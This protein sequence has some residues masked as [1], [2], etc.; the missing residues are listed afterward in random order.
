MSG[1]GEESP[2][3]RFLSPELP[4]LESIDRYFE[5]ARSAGWYSNEGPCYRLFVSRAQA[6]LGDDLFVV[7][8]A[9]CTLGL[10]L[11]LRALAG[12]PE[13]VKREVVVPSFT[14][15]ATAAAIEWAG[16][17]PVFADVDPVSWH[18]DPAALE[19]ALRER[20]QRVAGVLACSTFGV[21]PDPQ[22]T[23]AWERLTAAAGVPL[24][25]DSAAGFGATRRNGQRL[26]RQGD[27][28]AFSFHATKPFAVGEG[29]AV[30]TR[31]ESLADRIRVLTNFGFGPDRVIQGEAGL[32]AKLDEW[33]AAACLAALDTI[34]EVIAARRRHMASMRRP[35]ERLGFVFQ[36]GCENGTCQFVPVLASN[37]TVRA[38][39]MAR[40]TDDGVELRA[41]FDPPLHR[42][43]A[44]STCGTVGSLAVTES[45][46]AR[47]ISLPLANSFPP[48]ARERVLTALESAVFAV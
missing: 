13:G 31:D 45:L 43:N 37:P 10:L 34:D 26:G 32:N 1:T 35:L 46:A 17:T 9:N 47:M 16:F 41:Y 39:V 5:L 29:G 4:P 8:V 6:F 42:M 11:A 7:P 12:R 14:F 18:L 27:A 22:V 36:G 44:F 38:A 20:G 48:Q 23:E 28:E 25:V 30:V 15:A 2:I 3:I 21:P 33:H 19:Q 40:A 24:L